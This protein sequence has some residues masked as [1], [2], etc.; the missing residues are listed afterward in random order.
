MPVDD[1]IRGFVCHAVLTAIRSRFDTLDLEELGGLGDELVEFS[2]NP[3]FLQ[4]S[5]QL[6]A[7]ND[8]LANWVHPPAMPLDA[9]SPDTPRGRFQGRALHVMVEHAQHAPQQ[10]NPDRTFRDGLLTVAPPGAGKTVLQALAVNYAGVGRPMSSIDSRIRTAVGIMNSKLLILQGLDPSETLQQFLQIGGR[11]IPVGAHFQNR[12]D[13]HD[14]YPFI[15][16]TPESYKKGVERGAINPD[17]T[18]RHILDEAHR[19][20]L[21]PGMQQHVTQFGPSLFMFTATPAIAYGRRDLRRQFPHSQFG[22]LREFVEDEILC[23]IRLYSY[24]AGAEQGSEVRLAVSRA[25]EYLQSG[26]KTLVVCQPG[27]QLRQAREISDILNRLYRHGHIVLPSK[28]E[29]PDDGKIASAVGKFPGSQTQQDLALFKRG[30]RQIIM[31]VATGQ[32][33]LDIPDI[34]AIVIIGPQGSPWVVEQ[35]LGRALR[36]SGQM[37]IAAEILPHTLREGRPLASIFGAFGLEKEIIE[38]GLYIGPREH[39][40]EALDLPPPTTLTPPERERLPAAA[41]W[42]PDEATEREGL[43]PELQFDPAQYLVRDVS[44]REATIAP[45]DLAKIPPDDYAPLPPELAPEGVPIEWLYNILGKLDDPDIRYVGWYDY[46]EAGNLRYSR[47][48]SPAAHAYLHEHPVPELAGIAEFRDEQIAGI[49]GVSRKFVRSVID[50]LHIE[51]L[52][53]ITPCHRDPK[54]YGLDTLAA[55]AGEAE[56]MPVAAESDVAVPDL[57]REL[58]RAY[59]SDYIKRHGISASDKRRYAI[60]GTAGHITGDEADAIRSAYRSLAV[61]DKTCKVGFTEIATA[62][63]ASLSMV[64]NKFGALPDSE[65]PPTE[66]LRSTPKTR[67]AEFVDRRWGMAFAEYIRP[68][69]LLPWEATL[70]MVAQYFGKKKQNM[71]NMLTCRPHLGRPIHLRLPGVSDATIYPLSIIFRLRDEGMEPAADAPEIDET[72]VA[73]VP[74]DIHD[75]TKIA[76]SQTVQ[77][78]YVSPE[79]ISSPMKVAYYWQRRRTPPTLPALEPKPAPGMTAAPIPALAPKPTTQAHRTALSRTATIDALREPMGCTIEAF[80]I[81]LAKAGVE[82]SPDTPLTADAIRRIDV[83]SSMIGPPMSGWESLDATAAWCG[84][85]SRQA[86]LAAIDEIAAERGFPITDDEM[87]LCRRGQEVDIYIQRDNFGRG[88]RKKLRDGQ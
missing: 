66:W 19:T 25:V 45:A 34:D 61:A 29:M 2:Q 81:L 18:V 43:P 41:S 55:I 74:D 75:P 33:G 23:P 68:E 72:Q 59:V 24:R 67:P 70:T 73:L 83:A 44:V 48:Y 57:G 50:R 8:T 20:A 22:S 1:G 54:Y 27:G 9:D 11:E 21:A 52:P 56:N 58:N 65:R 4:L 62:A 64:L 15:L 6:G 16:T 87:R 36:P 88:L 35:W 63:G 30:R 76:N 69:K 82:N 28:F 14:E 7:A 77:R 38:P 79:H 13:G 31:T 12:S 10:A 84:R 37:A 42:G 40:G 47:Y 26:R 46:D 5:A 80:D 71:S 51:P 32:E 49:L 78:Y 60:L 86:V 85:R 53:R 3:N 39:S 17:T